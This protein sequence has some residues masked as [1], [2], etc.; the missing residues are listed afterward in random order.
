[1]TIADSCCRRSGLL[2]AAWL[3]AALCS[4]TSGASLA[5]KTALVVYTSFADA[6]ARAY[7]EAFEKAHPD[8]DVRWTNGSSA[9]LTARI[10]AER[11]APKADMV[12]GVTASL[13]MPLDAENMLLP[14]APAN[15]TAIA[16]RYRD[17]RHPPTYWWGMSLSGAAICFNADEAKKQKL[18]KPG[19]WRDLAKPVYKGKVAMPNPQTSAVGSFYVSGWLKMYGD[20]A[21]WKFM[22]G[23]NDNVTGYTL[24]ADTPCQRAAAGEIPIGLSFDGAAQRLKAAGAPIEVVVPAGD[25]PWDLWTVAILK[26][27][28]RVEPAQRLADWLSGKDAMDITARYTPLLSVPSPV[29]A[30]TPSVLPPDYEKRLLKYDFLAAGKAHDAVQAEWKKRYGAKAE[31]R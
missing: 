13:L 27:S 8:V 23:L 30:P 10:V 5:Q 6:Q 26:S 4:L 20:A 2:R 25:V 12:V 3:L 19:T 21:G 29:P 9:A 14:F 22:D 24:Q 1:M 11:A 28:T 7:K 18:P 15:L 17:P 16:P 31:P